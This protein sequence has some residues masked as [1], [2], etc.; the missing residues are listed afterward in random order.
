MLRAKALL[1]KALEL[2]PNL[3]FAW[4]GL[5]QFHYKASTVGIRGIPRTKARKRLLETAAQ[6]VLRNPSDADAQAVQGLAY[7]VNRLPGKALSACQTALQFNPN[8][9]EAN[10]CAGLA[11]MGLGRTAEAFPYFDKAARLNP[12]QRPFRLMHFQALAHLLVGRYDEAVNMARKAI[13]SNPKFKSSHFSLSSALAWSGDMEG[14]RAALAEFLKLDERRGTI[15]RLRAA[16]SH[17]S[18]NFDRVLEGLRR[19]GMPEK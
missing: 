9:E 3:G 13:A 6:A 4:T 18:P 15:E 1:E 7:R 5:A 2:D 12:Y 19:A 14:A 11:Q 10:V 8:H 17:M 16:N